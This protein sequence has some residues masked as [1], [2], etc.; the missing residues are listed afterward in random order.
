MSTVIPGAVNPTPCVDGVGFVC[1]YLAKNAP[2]VL[3]ILH[4]NEGGI[5]CSELRAQL[6]LPADLLGDPEKDV[7]VR[8]GD[9]GSFEAYLAQF[10]M[11]FDLDL[12]D[13]DFATA[14][15]GN[16][17]YCFR[18]RVTFGSLMSIFE[19]LDYHLQICGSR[20][21]CRLLAMT[22]AGSVIDGMDGMDF[23]G[24]IQ[25][26]DYEQLSSLRLT[27]A[28]IADLIDDYLARLYEY[29]A[30]NSVYDRGLEQNVR[31]NVKLMRVANQIDAA[32]PDDPTGADTGAAQVG[33]A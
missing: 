2:R 26:V 22:A 19:A 30:R 7:L 17:V 15:A 24:I 4:Q 25:A 3:D 11:W 18:D 31:K 10:P 1:A 33:D 8:A 13:P 16:I 5:Q 14:F 27:E 28:T 9:I 29:E 6:G 32:A 12:E 21:G 20:T 23:E